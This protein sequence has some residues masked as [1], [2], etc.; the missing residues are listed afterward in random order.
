MD[1]KRITPR[2]RDS[3]TPAAKVSASE[4]TFKL[5]YIPF[6]NEAVVANF[7]GSYE[8][9]AEIGGSWRVKYPISETLDDYI[10]LQSKTFLTF[11][12]PRER[13]FLLAVAKHIADYLYTYYKR[14][15][16]ALEDASAEKNRVIGKIYSHNQ[17]IHSKVHRTSRANNGK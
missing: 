2:N 1:K 6:I 13:K 7:G 12:Q 9:V 16:G 5:K 8:T 11:A 14:M 15:P 3:Q 17:G 4:L 10:I